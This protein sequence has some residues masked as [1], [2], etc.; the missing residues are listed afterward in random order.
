MFIKVENYLAKF[1]KLA[2]E[3]LAPRVEAGIKKKFPGSDFKLKIKDKTIFFFEL[4]PALKNEIF[5]RRAEIL[6]DLK[7]AIGKRAPLN[8]EFRKI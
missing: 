3:D 5:L 4:S 7:E 1:R 6:K 2:P 8:I